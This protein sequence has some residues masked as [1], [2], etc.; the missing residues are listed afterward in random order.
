VPA[1]DILL[2]FADAVVAGEGTDLDAARARLRDALGR[3]AVVDAAAVIANFQRM[4]R[5]ADATGIPLDREANLVS[6]PLQERLGID[7]FGSAANTPRVGAAARRL[8]R[9]LDPVLM[10][11]MRLIVRWRWGAGS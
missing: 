11:A 7:R 2:A 6:A 9:L 1:A 10:R 5:I 4:T 8:V 3:A